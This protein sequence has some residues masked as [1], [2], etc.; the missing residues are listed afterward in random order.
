[1]LSIFSSNWAINPGKDSHI[2]YNDTNVNLQRG[3][4][5]FGITNNK[6]YTLD[7]FDGFD[8]DI[9]ELMQQYIFKI[10]QNNNYDYLIMVTHDDVTNK[11]TPKILNNYL[12][13]LGCNLLKDL[14]FRG[15]YMM[16]YDLKKKSMVKEVCDNKYPIHEYFEVDGEMINLGIPIYIIV[17]NL[18]YFTKNMVDQLKKYTKNIHIIDNRSTYPKLLE[19]Y[20]TEYKFFI[21]KMGVNYG[22]T[23]WLNQLLWQMPRY[24]AITD[25]DLKFNDN[26]PSDFLNV[27]CTLT[28]KYKKGKA[29]LCLDISD[30]HLFYKSNN[31]FARYNIENWE[32]QFW[33][34]KID[35]N[36]YNA[37][38]D[39]TLCVVNREYLN[40]LD[41]IRVGGDFV[42]KHIPWYEGWHE[43]LPKEE[44]EFYKSNNISS[45]VLKLILDG[46]DKNLDENI[47]MI[48]DI[49]V[50]LRK[51]GELDIN[52]VDIKYHII[53]CMDA[54]TN[55]KSELDKKYVYNHLK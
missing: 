10:Y 53:K 31:Y 8:N 36:I 27:L 55:Y 7:F 24:F 29:G 34:N 41:G 22:H 30:A 32:K 47:K 4:N 50:V 45:S 43:S 3:Y 49:D 18:L 52:D 2:K 40:G 38:I 16:V 54:L 15:S 21:H 26:L 33:I 39:T 28:D 37:P 44:W 42:C 1:M 9:S 51:M 23:V 13:F 5:L 12:I 35:D 48:K 25:P 6:L 20:D 11:T 46:Q 14:Q 17:Y 19:Y